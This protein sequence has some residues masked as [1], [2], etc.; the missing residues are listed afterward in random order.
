[1]AVFKYAAAGTEGEVV[2]GIMEAKDHEAAVGKLHSMGYVPIRVEAPAERKPLEAGRI[3]L[4]GILWRL[5]ARGYVLNFI[6]ELAILL[7]AS[8]PLDRSLSILL[9]LSENPHF[10]SVLRNVLED[11][12]GGS[13]LAD[14]LSRHPKLFTKLHV[15]MVRAGE[16]SGAVGAVMGQLAEYLERSED[17]RDHIKSALIYPAILTVVTGA[18]VI[19]LVTV[20]VPRIASVFADLEQG[21]PVSAQVL[22]TVGD[23]VRGYWWAVLGVPVCAYLG[24]RSYVRSEKGRVRWDRFK[25][26]VRYV[27]ELLRKVEIARFAGVMSTLLRSGVQI[28]DAI[29]ISQQTL[30]NRVVGDSLVQVHDSVREGG[31]LAVPL[32]ATDCFPPLA[33]RMIALGEE[34]GRLEDMM[35]QV[36]EQYEKETRRSIDRSLAFLEPMIVLFM[37]LVVGTIVVTMLL[38]VFS[39]N[40]IEF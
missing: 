36:A 14:A 2:Q 37:G 39:V 23:I 5:T 18:S 1:M 7:Q 34:T 31:G 33:V 15:N 6:R 27:G 12:E 8:L 26:D 29:T 11:V 16:A 19:I 10:K 35:Q 28:L 4:G 9:E 40:D 20:V 13:S 21:M 38:A 22:V 24:F 3:P 32:A 30:T 25:L 17:L